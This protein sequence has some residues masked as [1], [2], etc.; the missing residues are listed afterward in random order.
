MLDETP[1]RSAD[2]EA[3]AQ[4][5]AG[6]ARGRDSLS[7]YPFIS[8]LMGGLCIGLGAGF[9]TV[10]T[11]QPAA[12]LGVTQLLGGL[13]FSVGPAL[14]A[15]G[16]VDVFAGSPT[17]VLAWFR[18]RATPADW[19]RNWSWVYVGNLVGA[20]ALAW[21][22]FISGQYLMRGADAADPLVGPRILAIAQ[23]KCAAPFRVALVRGI[24]GGALVCLALWFASF[25][26]GTGA[27][28]LAVALPGTALIACGF[29]HCVANMYLASAG[30]A[31]HWSHAIAD[32]ETA[33][34]LG[35]FIT[36]SLIPCTLGNIVGA[37]LTL[38]GLYWARYVVP[39]TRTPRRRARP[40]RRSS[41]RDPES[42][43]TR[44]RASARRD[45][46]SR[47]SDPGE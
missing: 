39:N 15:L 19:A 21:L 40:D 36:R 24:L 5:V 7:S 10:V 16:G 12:G 20:V 31:L 47:R 28:I 30:L 42:R 11:T 1:Q 4:S 26:R 27:K 2:S 17:V 32:A 25:S 33:I 6:D 8:G 14:V 29:E 9:Y 34:S 46:S 43:S 37:F 18:G 41:T 35:T 22:V 13:A 44:R 23:E 3:D 45:T 38:G